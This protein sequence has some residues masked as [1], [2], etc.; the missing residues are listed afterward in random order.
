[1]F[2]SVKP[3]CKCKFTLTIKSMLKSVY[4]H[5]KWVEWSLECSKVNLQVC[6]QLALLSYCLAVWRCLKEPHVLTM[7]RP[8]RPKS[9]STF[10][11]L[12][13]LMGQ[14]LMNS[15]EREKQGCLLI[16]RVN[17][18]WMFGCVFMCL[19]VFFL[20][21]SRIF[22]LIY[23][24]I[25]LFKDKKERNSPSLNCKVTVKTFQNQTKKKE[26]WIRAEHVENNALKLSLI[27]GNQY[28]VTEPFYLQEGTHVL[29]CNKKPDCSV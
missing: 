8:V 4:Y 15:V 28:T 25:G 16:L 3:G 11:D 27:L 7:W 10:F 18:Q 20:M 5:Y 21:F 6:F 24:P 19:R 22:V 9:V 2:K 17:M 12:R 26:Y 13:R 29:S 1:M 14:F 23:Y